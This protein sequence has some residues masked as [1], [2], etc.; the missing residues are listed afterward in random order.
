MGL[1]VCKLACP[2]MISSDPV[3]T[4]SSASGEAPS[5]VKAEVQSATQVQGNPTPPNSTS[6]QT[7]LNQLLKQVLSIDDFGQHSTALLRQLALLVGAARGR[8]YLLDTT[9]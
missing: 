8:I 2:K 4:I 5:P 7:T 6:D 3:T 9:K 1:F